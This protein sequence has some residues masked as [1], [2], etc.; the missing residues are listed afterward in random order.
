MMKLNI[1]KSALLA[2]A[3]MVA[4]P[5]ACTQEAPAGSKLVCVIGQNKAASIA[6]AALFALWVDMKTNSNKEMFETT[7]TEDCNKIA[8]SF[9]LFDAEFYK[10]VA[11]LLR[12]VIAGRPVKFVN[13][14]IPQEDGSTVKGKKTLGQAPYGALGLF[15][16]YVLSQI[17]DFSEN[18]PLLAGFYVLLGSPEFAWQNTFKKASAEAK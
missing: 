18:I 8:Q 6:A 9:N 3:M 12:K 17:K 2:V 1:G 10:K 5:A 4:V 11:T 16:A 15:D 7:L 13:K 14:D